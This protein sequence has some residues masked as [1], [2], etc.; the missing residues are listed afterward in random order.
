MGF[1]TYIHT[2]IHNINL[3]FLTAVSTSAVLSHTFKNVA[4]LRTLSS[5]SHCLTRYH[6]HCHRPCYPTA[7]SYN[8]LIMSHDRH[9]S[10]SSIRGSSTT[11]MNG[12]G[13]SRESR[14]VCPRCGEPFKAA[15]S[16]MS[17]CQLSCIT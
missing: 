8:S 16:T 6:Q 9:M 1:S 13:K 3:Y 10:S 2:Y 15:N 12:S 17:M 5:V 7:M 14:P 11:D 4:M